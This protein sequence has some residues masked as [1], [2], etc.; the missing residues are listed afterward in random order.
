MPNVRFRARP[1][2]SGTISCAQLVNSKPVRCRKRK[3]EVE[4]TQ[5]ISKGR[6]FGY[7]LAAS[8]CEEAN[9]GACTVTTL[10]VITAFACSNRVT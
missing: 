3:E 4:G 5:K 10:D 9:S 8:S 1:F 6:D 2:E 7:P